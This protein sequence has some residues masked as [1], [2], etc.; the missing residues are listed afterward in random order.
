MSIIAN[1]MADEERQIKVTGDITL[2]GNEVPDSLE[3]SKTYSVEFKKSND[4]YVNEAV[5]KVNE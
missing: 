5:I 1:N 3:T 4:G 2:T